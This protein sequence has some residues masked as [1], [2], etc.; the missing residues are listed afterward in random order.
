[1]NNIYIIKKHNLEVII[2]YKL[3]SLTTQLTLLFFIKPVNLEI[4]AIR[5]EIEKSRDLDFSYRDLSFRAFY[6]QI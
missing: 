4:F 1:M 3:I 5:D 2:I 6:D